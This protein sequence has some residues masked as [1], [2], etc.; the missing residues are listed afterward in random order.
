MQTYVRRDLRALFVPASRCA[1]LLFR[2]NAQHN[3]AVKHSCVKQTL[4]SA[5]E[6]G[7]SALSLG[8]GGADGRLDGNAAALHRPALTSIMM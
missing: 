6:L 4:R 5:V 7:L 1:N 3:F 2:K 8:G